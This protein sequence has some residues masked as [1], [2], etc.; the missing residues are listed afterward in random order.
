MTGLNEIMKQYLAEEKLKQF[1]K[2][3]GL[4]DQNIFQRAT[5]NKKDEKVLSTSIDMA[6]QIL[7]VLNRCFKF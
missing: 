7:G 2:M 1:L 4:R 6:K 5:T 3:R